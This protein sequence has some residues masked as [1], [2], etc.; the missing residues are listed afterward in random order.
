MKP[1][2]IFLLCIGFVANT[3]AA[4]RIVNESHTI[5]A[6]S[7][8]KT[9]AS[10][11]ILKSK[12]EKTNGWSLAAGIMGL[13]S[14]AMLGI[15]FAVGFGA[16]AKLMVAGMV[17]AMAATETGR[18]SYYQNKGRKSDRWAKVGIWSGKSFLII[19]SVYLV[20]SL[21]RAWICLFTLFS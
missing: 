3:Q 5:I 8:T 14:L 19:T 2:L 13:V 18:L 12:S 21:M 4:T 9:A 17:L 11:L 7:T 10:S 20:F 6:D 1:I 16:V 15:G